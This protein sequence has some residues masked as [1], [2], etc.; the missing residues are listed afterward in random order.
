MI[1]YLDMKQGSA[2]W[3]ALRKTKV[4][5]TDA[6]VIMGVSPWK[7]VKSLLQDKLYS[8]SENIITPKMQRGIDL[9]PIARDL[10]NI[11]TGFLLIPGVVVNGWAM[12]SLD[13]ISQDHQIILEIKCPGDK[14]HALALH[15]QIPEYYYPQLQHQMSVCNLQS[16]YYFSFDGIDGVTI[17][18]PRDDLYIEKMLIEEKKF[19]A[20]L[21]A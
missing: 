14:D 18:V 1:E 7:S 8:I 19:Y 20:L 15:G 2:E 3:H 17:P 21:V 13:G 12:A 11:Q 6:A 5:A 16:M 10:F 4:T 9:E